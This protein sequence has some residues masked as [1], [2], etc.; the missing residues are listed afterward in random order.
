M[1][2]RCGYGVAQERVSRR[3]LDPA[4]NSVTCPCAGERGGTGLL[5]QPARTNVK[6]DCIRGTGP[7]VERIATGH[8]PQEA[9]STLEEHYVRSLARQKQAACGAKWEA[10]GFF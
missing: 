5:E 4:R 6:L 3:I 8:R 9:A 1:S 10:G 2:G 7:V